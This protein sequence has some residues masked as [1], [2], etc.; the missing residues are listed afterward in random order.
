MKDFD[1]TAD[2]LYQ[3]CRRVQKETNVSVGF[4]VINYEDGRIASVRIYD[5]IFTAK[6]NMKMYYICENGDE[7]ENI[8]ET[9]NHLNQLLINK[10]CLYCEEDCNG[11]RKQDGFQ[12]RDRS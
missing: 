8:Q 9:K 5:G 7:E 3:L 4:E 12:S 6:A 2:E 11:E 10:P 1:K